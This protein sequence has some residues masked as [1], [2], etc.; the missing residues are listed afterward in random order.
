M[1]KF[2]VTK[3]QYCDMLWL[4]AYH[5]ASKGQAIEAKPNSFCRLFKKM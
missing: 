1:L 5:S 2:I 4:S 3:I